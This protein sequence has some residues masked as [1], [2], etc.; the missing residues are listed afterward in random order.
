MCWHGLWTVPFLILREKKTRCI[1]DVSATLKQM[2]IIFIL[3]MTGFICRKTG[4]VFITF[5][6]AAGMFAFMIIF[7]MLMPVILDRAKTNRYNTRSC[8]IVPISV[9]WFYVEGN[10]YLRG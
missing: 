9:R 2:D 4:L 6:V 10:A 7:A 5:A 3:V 8:G 1:M